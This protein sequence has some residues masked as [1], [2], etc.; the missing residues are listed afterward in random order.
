MI[1]LSRKTIFSIAE[2]CEG[3]NISRTTEHALPPALR[4]LSIKV[5]RRRLIRESPEEWAQRI[6]RAQSGAG[7]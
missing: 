1:E 2:W 3:A 5:G 6:A 4:P 7:E